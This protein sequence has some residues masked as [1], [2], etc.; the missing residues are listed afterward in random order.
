MCE[1][2]ETMIAAW[3]GVGGTLVAGFGGAWLGAK[4]A[5]DAGRHLL[6]QQ[7][8]AEFTAAFTDTIFKLSGPAPENRVGDALHILTTDYPRHFI[9]YIRLRSVLSILE[10]RTIDDAW[11]QYVKDDKDDSPEEREFYRFK[12]VLNPDTDEH[13]YMLAVKRINTLLAKAAA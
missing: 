12:D 9:A 4:I 13:Q 10:Q 3:L 2:S 7:A 8:K 11:R 6:S 1:M 5:R